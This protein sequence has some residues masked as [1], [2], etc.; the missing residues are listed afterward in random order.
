MRQTIQ[1]TS[2]AVE[3][4]RSP[5]IEYTG[6]AIRTDAVYVVFTSIEETLA[7]VHVAGDFARA[8]G[9]PVTLVHFRPVPYALPVDQPCGIS[10]VETEAFIARLRAERLDVRV[11]VWSCRD[12]RRAMRLAFK[13]HSLIVVAGR[14]HWWPTRS[15]R[16]RRMLDQAGH[17]VVFVDMS[18]QRVRDGHDACDAPRVLQKETVHA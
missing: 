4:P 16:L 10:P 5:L 8:L 9:V 11:R 7:A 1:L 18:E 14:R 17:F 12:E 2:T 3:T 6:P 15:R 13:G